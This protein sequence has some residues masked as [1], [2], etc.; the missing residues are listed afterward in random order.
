MSPRMQRLVSVARAAWC[1]TFALALAS[2]C[3]GHSRSAGD[4]GTDA[5]GATGRAGSSSS[6][7]GMAQAGSGSSDDA[8][9]G[10]SE[11]G[12]CSAAFQRW[13]HDSTTGVCK[14][15]SYGGCGATKNNYETLEACQKACPGRDPGYDACK[16][17]TDCVLASPGCCGVCDG[18]SIG[19]QDFLAYNKAYQAKVPTCGPGNVACGA[20]PDPEP[21]TNTR[22]Y[23][24]PNCVNG[25]CVVEDIRE[26]A[27]TAC[28]TGE[29]C[30]LRAGTSCCASCGTYDAVAVRNDGSL[31]KLVCGDVIPP[32]LPCDPGMAATAVPTCNRNGHCEVTFVL[33]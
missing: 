2:A 1:A 31:D 11:L 24:I 22:Q 32:C 29:D 8:C 13:T 26:S 23:F 7:G 5:G 14:P 17:P 18:P 27:V 12:S 3:G 4:D 9:A 6:G 21:S 10:P 33:Q 30:E 25:E 16:A 28:A 20:C 15:V 19:K